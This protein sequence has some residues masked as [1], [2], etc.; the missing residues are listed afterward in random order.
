MISSRHDSNGLSDEVAPLGEAFADHEIPGV[1]STGS[2]TGPLEE[3]PTC[4]IQN[5]ASTND[6]T[7]LRIFHK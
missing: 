6:K 1:N 5:I 4:V 7:D 3:S 2:A